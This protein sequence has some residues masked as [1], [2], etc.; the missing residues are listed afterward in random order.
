MLV[1][2]GKTPATVL[3]WRS[4]AWFSLAVL[5]L[6]VLSLTPYMTSS[7]EL[8]RLRNALLY[9]DQTPVDFNWT[10]A[11][12]P[13]S[14]MLE[15]GPADPFFI[16]IAQRLNLAALPTDWDRVLAI[17]RHLLGSSRTL[18]GG[19]IMSDLRGTYTRIVSDGDGYCGDFVD[20]FMAIALAADMPVRAWAFSFDGFG[21]D[22]HVWVE[23]WN[24][25]LGRWQ[26]IDIFNNYFFFETEGL[27]LSAMEFRQALSSN[28]SQLKLNTLYAVARVGWIH[29]EKAWDYYRRGLPEWY[30]WWG[31]NVFT[32]DGALLVRSFSGLSR[33]M[34]QL[35]GV[36]QGISPSLRVLVTEANQSKTKTLGKIRTHLIVVAWVGTIAALA[37]L[38]CWGASMRKTR[39]QAHA[40]R[41][42]HTRESLPRIGLVGPLSPPSGGMANQ[43]EQLIRLLRSEGVDVAL[44]QTNAPYHPAWAGRIPVLRAAFRLVPYLAR[45]WIVAGKVDVMHIQAN[46]GWAWH[47]FVAPAITIARLQLTPVIV[48]YHGGNADQFLNTAPRYVLRML[49]SA[50]MRVVP[51]IFLQRIFPKHGL[52]ADVIPNIVDLSRFKPAAARAFGDSPHIVVTRNLETV[53]DI[54]TA[55]RAF[56]IVKQSFAGATLT[57][58]GSGPE[59]SNLQAL[60]VQLGLTSCVRFAGRIDNANIPSLYASADCMVNASTVD[61]MPISILEAFASGVPV[62]STDAGGIPDMVDHGVSGLLVPVGDYASMARKVVHILQH[63]TVEASLREAGL[64]QAKKFSWSQVRTLWLSAYVKFAKLGRAL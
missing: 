6:C 2:Q 3:R 50:A 63:P 43:T 61:N 29:E 11:N 60:V 44:V 18:H 54:P 14:F 57:V 33:S 40:T 30:M 12:V 9:T 28:S 38:I 20:V 45:L 8:V 25:H 64:A 59:L 5:V 47:L 35:G 56:A 58:A 7:T 39:R 53:Y 49:G 26:L 16:A 32:Y 10:P 17:S 24:R 41:D 31:N 36:V 52:D 37:T 55:I 21:G 34:E 15:R 42:T 22:G 4:Y 62:V 19:A 27:P 48:N 51:S 1:D 23:I 13:P 46:S